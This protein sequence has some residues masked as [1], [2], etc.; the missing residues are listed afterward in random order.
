MT[1]VTARNALK[2]ISIP[3]AL[4][5]TLLL[6]LGL[7]VQ[8]P[9]ARGL[10]RQDLH[11]VQNFQLTEDFLTRYQ[12]VQKDMSKNPAQLGMT[13]ITHNTSR[14]PRQHGSFDEAIAKWTSRS[15]VSE[16]LASHDMSAR[17]FMVGKAALAFAHI[18]YLKQQHP[19]LAKRMTNKDFPFTGSDASIA[20]YAAHRKEIRQFMRKTGRKMAQRGE[21]A[22][23]CE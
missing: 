1:V 18:G 16:M 14:P 11:T 7:L 20:F 8:S 22:R 6:G 19:K 9:A 5:C 12:A 4:L 13:C 23:S 17:E 3:A 15:G 10:T 21:R 2:S